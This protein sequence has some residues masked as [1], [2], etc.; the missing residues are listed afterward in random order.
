MFTRERRRDGEYCRRPAQTP[1]QLLSPP[2]KTKPNNAAR[3]CNKIVFSLNPSHSLLRLIEF[4]KP[5]QTAGVTFCCPYSL[6]V[7][8]PPIK[9][10]GIM[11]NSCM[12]L[13][14]EI[15]AGKLKASLYLCKC[16][17]ELSTWTAQTT[18][19]LPVCRQGDASRQCMVCPL[20]KI[21][22]LLYCWG[23]VINWLPC[24]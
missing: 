8:N 14:N 9:H 15:V 24:A 1:T 17:P 6:E 23:L 2:H 19:G 21:L 22:A 20:V 10:Q 18:C 5:L 3:L 16:A 13:R 12:Q 4:N 7:N 11:K